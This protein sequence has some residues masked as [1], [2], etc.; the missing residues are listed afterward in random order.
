MAMDLS[1]HPGAVLAIKRPIPVRVAFAPVAGSLQ[2]LE[3]AVRYRAGAAL[4]T[5]PGGER[6]PVEREAFLASYEPISPTQEGEDGSY[7]KKKAAVVALQLQAPIS[8]PVGYDSDLIEGRPGDW[9]V[10][11]APGNHGVV[12]AKIFSETYELISA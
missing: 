1:K 7:R 5:G 12:G 11:Y 8:I 10:Q 9:L 2:T 4:L 3:G 6:W